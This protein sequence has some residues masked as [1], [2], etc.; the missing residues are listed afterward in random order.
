M[1]TTT[2][3]V[4]FFI[5]L[6]LFLMLGCNGAPSDDANPSI[7]N[8]RVDGADASSG[9]GE[10]ELNTEPIFTMNLSDNRELGEFQAQVGGV[11]NYMEQLEGTGVS[12]DYKFTIDADIYEV[13]DMIPITFILE[14]QAGNINFLLYSITVTE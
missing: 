10:H 1:N 6:A 11:I 8:L 3:I 13:G 7:S 4:T 5:G 2:K 9:M 14:D 12:M